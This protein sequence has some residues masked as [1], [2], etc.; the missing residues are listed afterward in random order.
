[1]AA[2]PFLD[3]VAVGIEAYRVRV[4][5]KLGYGGPIWLSHSSFA[6]CSL[7]ERGV[8]AAELDVAEKVETFSTVWTPFWVAEMTC[9]VTIRVLFGLTLSVLGRRASSCRI[10]LSLGSF[11]FCSARTAKGLI[12]DEVFGPGTLFCGWG[13]RGWRGGMAL[14]PLFEKKYV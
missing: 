4:T 3:R 8:A 9:F 7:E 13:L 6:A 12:R 1:M 2:K 5:P 14:R 11:K 10:R